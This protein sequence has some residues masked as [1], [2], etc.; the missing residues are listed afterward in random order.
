[1]I[2]T[3]N[4]YL[5][6]INFLPPRQFT[7]QNSFAILETLNILNE[8]I[9]NRFTIFSDSISCLQGIQQ[10]NSNHPIISDIQSKLIELQHFNKFVDLCWVP[11]H[12]NIY[13]NEQADK[14]AKAGSNLDSPPYFNKV[15]FKDDYR[16][17]KSKVKEKWSSKWYNI[18]PE[19]N[20]L[21]AIK[22]TIKPWSTSSNTKS[23]KA[24]VVLCRLRI[25]HTRLTHGYLMEGR[26]DNECPH[27]GDE[28]NSIKHIFCEC[29]LYNR[30]RNVCFHNHR[31]LNTYK[32]NTM[33]IYI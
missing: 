28:P 24:E 16:H 3:L 22:S 27:C 2:F 21:R 32:G 33:H 13:G 8:H 4:N 15:H 31:L 5:S 19:L 1:M 9:G 26:R 10:L 17:I 23:R 29:P 30:E 20:K 7:Q 11:S 6:P 18:S 12:I 14:L 25:G